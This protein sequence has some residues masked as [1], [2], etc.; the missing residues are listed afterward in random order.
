MYVRSNTPKYVCEAC[1]NKITIE[2][3]EGIFFERLTTFS[4]SANEVAAHLK[5]ANSGLAELEELLAV[6]R[7][8]QAKVKADMDRLMDLYLAGE[9]PKEGF[10][11]H[12]TPLQERF[13]QLDAEIPRLQG[14]IDYGKARMLTQDEILAQA[15]N[16]Y[17]RWPKM[18]LEKKRK[19]VDAIVR[20]VTIGRENIHFDLF[21]LRSEEDP[22]DSSE[23]ENDPQPPRPRKSPPHITPANS[24]NS[25]S[26]QDMAK[27]SRYA[28]DW[29][30]SP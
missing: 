8:N 5:R 4:L 14:E 7:K 17:D 30:A 11:S 10:G 18:S 29:S 27:Y 26:L 23:P 3:L 28:Q 15:Q 19:V 20:K 25:A 21:Y 6:A 12:Y 22:D 13:N 1:R 9:I 2:L 24:K 16:L